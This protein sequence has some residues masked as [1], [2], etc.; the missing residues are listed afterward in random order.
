MEVPT[1]QQELFYL[2]KYGTGMFGNLSQ[3]ISFQH[4]GRALFLVHIS[5]F[6]KDVEA[7]P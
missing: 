2:P 4:N 6:H 7:M 1:A 3:Q 5:S